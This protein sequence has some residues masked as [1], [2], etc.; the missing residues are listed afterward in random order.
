[1]RICIENIA[2]FGRV[3]GLGEG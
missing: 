2:G 3:K 1:M